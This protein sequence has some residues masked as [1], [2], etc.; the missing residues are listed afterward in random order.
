MYPPPSRTDRNLWYSVAAGIVILAIL[1]LAPI[2]LTGS[3]GWSPAPSPVTVSSPFIPVFTDP[4]DKLRETASPAFTQKLFLEAGTYEPL[5]H[6]NGTQVHMGFWS[7]RGNHGSLVRLLDAI[8]D[9]PL[10]ADRTP[11]R[12]IWD[13]GA[14]TSNQYPSYVTMLNEHWYERASPRNGTV[15]IFGAGFPDPHPVTLAEADTIWGQYSQRYADMAEP[16]MQATGKPVKVWCYVEG[17]RANRIFYTYEFPELR[18][19]EQDGIVTVYFAK[20]RDANWTQ[21]GDWTIGTAN[22]P[23][24]VM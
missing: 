4:A 2:A 14:T 15:I 6:M 10:S 18:H 22:A 8:N 9:Q 19:M 13:E 3:S 16:I 20:S 1:V 7:G 24:P 23:A 17:A 12:A 21:A 11:Q 5:L